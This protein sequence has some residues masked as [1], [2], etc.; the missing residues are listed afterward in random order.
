MR[1]RRSHGEPHPAGEDDEGRPSPFWERIVREAAGD[2]A[3]VL[4]ENLA[5]PKASADAKQQAPEANGTAK[6]DAAFRAAFDRLADS[7]IDEVVQRIQDHSIVYFEYDHE[8]ASL[9]NAARS[10]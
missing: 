8:T 4:N 7:A 2:T 10:N 6:K 1:S 5:E 9:R 3:E